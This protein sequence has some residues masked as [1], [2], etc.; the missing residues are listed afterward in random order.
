MIPL[1]AKL[2][3][4]GADGPHHPCSEP[5]VARAPADDITTVLAFKSEREWL[6]ECIRGLPSSVILIP[7]ACDKS[8]SPERQTFT[9]ASGIRLSSK[10]VASERCGRQNTLKK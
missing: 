1:L 3:G 9:N 2:A 7:I 8:S 5:A 10:N 6:D 4:V